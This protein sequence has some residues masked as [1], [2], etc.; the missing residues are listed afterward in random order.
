MANF[1]GTTSDD[2][3]VDDLNAN[4][5][6]LGYGGDD[7]VF[8][9]D[10]QD[11]IYGNQG[12]DSLD[13]GTGNDT[14]FGGQDSDTL[15]G[16]EGDDL[17]NGNLG[18][19]QVRGGSGN[20][21]LYG[22]KGNDSITGGTGSDL[23]GGD[24]GNDTLIGANLGDANPGVGEIDTLTGGS[25]VDRFV[26]GDSSKVFYNDGTG[27]SFSYAV[28]TDFNL[29]E[30]SIQLKGNVSNY[31]LGG[32]PS[33]FPTG[34]SIYLDDDGIVGFTAGDELIAIAQGVPSL[35]LT[36]SYFNFV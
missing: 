20:D 24:N 11:T 1:L 32:S 22:G 18:N 23:I 12:N 2:L 15:V 17:L 27:S 16:R 14:I 29:S 35:S 34:I 33:G 30:D 9:L 4:S 36:S 31:V 21:T 13:G 19:D 10:G 28:I 8:G 26:L 5:S 6:F 7:T 25:G 3:L